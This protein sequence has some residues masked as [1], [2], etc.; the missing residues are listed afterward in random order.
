MKKKTKKAYSVEVKGQYILIK[1]KDYGYHYQIKLE[2]DG[3]VF[4][5]IY[6][7]VHSKDED[8]VR[9]MST[10][11]VYN[12]EELVCELCGEAKCLMTCEKEEDEE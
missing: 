1:H 6:N 9:E 11:Y 3:L 4:D 10:A 5:I 2:E 7:K 12:D 8:H